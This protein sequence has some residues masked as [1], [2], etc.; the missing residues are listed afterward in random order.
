MCL[1]IYS[2]NPLKISIDDMK[3]AYSSNKDGFGIMYLKDN[4]IIT[5]KI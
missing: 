1:I 2:K 3:Q 4:K 5:E